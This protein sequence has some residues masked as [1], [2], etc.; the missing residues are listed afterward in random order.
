MLRTGRFADWASRDEQAR[1][2]AAASQARGGLS[3]V[4]VPMFR[5]VCERP[6][7][8]KARS[9]AC[10]MRPRT[11]SRHE[12][13]SRH[14]DSIMASTLAVPAMPKLCAGS[15]LTAQSASDFAQ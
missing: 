9:M 12:A 3:R 13:V 2:T 10:P 1:R 11:F 5:L 14:A 15:I 4:S 8:A 6:Q 7:W